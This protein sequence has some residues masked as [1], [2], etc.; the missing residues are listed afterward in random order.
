MASSAVGPCLLLWDRRGQTVLFSGQ[1]VLK[2]EAP[3]CGREA[4]LEP[5]PA[6][7]GQ[8]FGDL[9]LGTMRGH[10]KHRSQTIA[11]GRD[12]HDAVVQRRH[13]HAVPRALP[14]R[15]VGNRTTFARCGVS[16]PGIV[17]KVRKTWMKSQKVLGGPVRGPRVGVDL[18]PVVL[19]VRQ[20]VDPAPPAVPRRRGRGT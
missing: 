18:H 12:R 8:T 9:Q 5:V 2:A 4:R 17:S 10:A 20:L 3:T 6:F 13:V 19:V 14:R 7:Q 1:L 11:D 15:G 16:Y